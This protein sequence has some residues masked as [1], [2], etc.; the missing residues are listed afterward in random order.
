MAAAAVITLAPLV[1]PILKPIVT[2]L[3]V[4]LEHLF[5]TKTGPTKFATAVSTTLGIA[6]QLAA[7]GK[8]PGSIDGVTVST[9]VE[10]VVQELKSAN[11]LTPSITPPSVIGGIPTGA[12]VN[13]TG[14][15]TLG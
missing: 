12:S 8:I 11:I 14:T 4:H 10:S 6:D 9:L 13:V 2:S 1:V 3:V 5:G 7:A 15:L